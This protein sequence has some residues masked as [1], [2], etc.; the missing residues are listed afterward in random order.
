MLKGKDVK[1]FAPFSS[2]TFQPAIFF[3]SVFYHFTPSLVMLTSTH[4]VKAFQEWE[5]LD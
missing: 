2:H 1:I 5:G 4:N 3:L